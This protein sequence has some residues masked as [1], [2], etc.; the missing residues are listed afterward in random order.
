MST[1]KHIDK[2]CVVVT[3]LSL[4]LALLFMNGE[5]FGI[6]RIVD[7]DREANSD[8]AYFT[9]SDLDGEW[10]DSTATKITL[11][12]DSASIS[13]NGAYAYDGGVVINNAGWF[14]ISGQLTDGS[15]VVNA[16]SGSKV[17]IRLN[18]VKVNA[19]DT[20]ALIV[21]QADKVFL[22]LAEGTENTFTSGTEYTDDAVNEG[23]SGVIFARDDL[24]INGSGSLSVSGGI[25]HGIVAKDDLVITGGNIEVEASG[26]AVHAN[27]SVRVC[28]AVLSLTAGDDGMVAEKDDAWIY[29]LSG[30][31]SI[32]AKDEGILSGMDITI[33]GGAYRISVGT[34]Q[35][36]HGIKATNSCTIKGGNIDITSCYEGI[37]AKYIDIYDGSLNIIPADDG[38]NASTGGS[39]GFGG[40]G[41]GM[42]TIDTMGGGRESKWTGQADTTGEAPS[43]ESSDSTEDNSSTGGM[44][45]PGRGQ[46]GMQFPDQSRGGMQ[47]PDQSQGGMQFPDQSQSG[48]QMPDQGQSGMQMPDQDQSGMQMPDQNRGE[49]QMPDQDQRGMQFPGN[50][51]ELQDATQASSDTQAGSEVSTQ[52]AGNMGGMS[53]TTDIPWLHISGGKITID[54]PSSRDADGL[55]S[56]GDI[57]I[58]GGT[59]RVSLTGEGSNSA[60][61]YGSENGGVCRITGGN[62]IACGSYSMAEGFDSSSTQCSVLY[63]ISSAVEG[64]TL[65]SLENSDGDVLLEYEVPNSFSSVNISCPEMVLGETYTVIIG[66]SHEEITLN[67]IA[68]SY[69]NAQSTMFGGNMNWGG[70]QQGGRGSKTRR[71]SRDSTDASTETDT[72]LPEMPT[73]GS[74]PEMPTDGSMP[75][76]ST[77]GS[78]PEM[79]TDG[80][81]PDSTGQDRREGQVE[82]AVQE[83]EETTAQ[84]SAK[85]MTSEGWILIIASFGILALGI[86]AVKLVKR[87]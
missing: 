54:N 79:P 87:R 60:I 41:G 34:D 1:H 16:A 85:D 86:L 71:E 81:L 77:D 5:A 46:G 75:E 65:V 18:G 61:D 48:M 38:L 28:N 9:A 42:G 66:D 70:M 15:I 73:D 56:N 21:K 50:T 27:D 29:L 84:S 10:N 78:M 33:L 14:T 3:L 32:D 63:N 49:M 82:G 8:S 69:G 36:H 83:V 76:M 68:A 74:M 64:G 59:I 4:I 26:D 57:I 2:I 31:L 19:Q 45:L 6:E 40:M 39:S 62:I 23:I 17:W 67:D 43:E 52:A 24:T 44:E 11:D 30:D 35:G 55:D 13:G 7:E 53:D 80:N 58:S 20:A 51:E 37:Q 25:K 12:K 72:T 47:F 22:T